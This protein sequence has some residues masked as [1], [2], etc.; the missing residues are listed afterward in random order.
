[1][2]RSVGREDEPEQRVVGGG[3]EESEQLQMLAWYKNRLLYIRG[4]CDLCTEYSLGEIVDGSVRVTA[5]DGISHGELVQTAQEFVAQV[6]D[7][8]ILM[9]PYAGLRSR[10]NGT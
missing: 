5:G 4:L 2:V 3:L 9:D 6:T 8:E 7:E 10:I 1:M